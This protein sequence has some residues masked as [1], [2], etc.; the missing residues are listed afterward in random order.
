[1]AIPSKCSATIIHKKRSL[2]RD[3]L[4]AMQ[5]YMGRWGDGNSAVHPPHQERERGTE[6]QHR[7][8]LQFQPLR[9]FLLQS[10]D[11]IGLSFVFT[12]S[13]L[14]FFVQF[15]CVLKVNQNIWMQFLGLHSTSLLAHLLRLQKP[16]M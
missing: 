16:A 8:K 14:R 10:N 11:K 2:H 3:K 7:P 4:R 9:N 6:L 1:M 12:A 13:V 5:L 15:E